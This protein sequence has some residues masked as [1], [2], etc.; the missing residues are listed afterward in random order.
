MYSFCQRRIWKIHIL[1]LYPLLKLVAN[2]NLNGKIF[3]IHLPLLHQKVRKRC[4]NQIIQLALRILLE[5]RLCRQQGR[6]LP[7][8]GGPRHGL[9]LYSKGETTPPIKNI[10]IRILRYTVSRR[11]FVNRKN[12]TICW[13]KS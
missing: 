4:A 11:V 13:I 8:D 1:L 9:L 7:S 2:Q 5:E 10:K 12:I 6:A 3:R